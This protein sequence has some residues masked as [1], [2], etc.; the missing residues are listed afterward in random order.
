[1]RQLGGGLWTSGNV[2]LNTNIGLKS[3]L[4]KDKGFALVW[5]L[6]VFHLSEWFKVDIM[7]FFLAEWKTSSFEFCYGSSSHLCACVFSSV[8]MT[9]VRMTSTTVCRARTMGMTST[10]TSLRWKYDNPWWELVSQSLPFYSGP[11]RYMGF[12]RLMLIQ[13]LWSCDNDMQWKQEISHLTK[14]IPNIAALNSQHFPYQL[15]DNGTPS[16]GQTT[17]LHHFKSLV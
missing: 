2:L 12:F 4:M 3:R 5:L 10:R 13:I 15:L 6:S 16:G 1:M 11:D 17:Y 14:F 8:S 7:S 9:W